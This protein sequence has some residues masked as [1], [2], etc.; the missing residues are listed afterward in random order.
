VTTSP[1]AEATEGVGGYIMDGLGS[2]GSDGNATTTTDD[3]FVPPAQQTTN[4][5]S[6]M[7]VVRVWWVV[8][9]WAM[10]LV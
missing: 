6:S 4:G 10:F 3:G 9:A 5:A 2:A 1:P 7:G 8:W